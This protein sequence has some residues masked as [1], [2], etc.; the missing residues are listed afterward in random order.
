MKKIA[1]LTSVL[2]LA[3]CSK[4]TANFGGNT[5]AWETPASVR[6]ANANVTQMETWI[7]SAGDVIAWVEGRGVN[8][9]SGSQ[10]SLRASAIREAQSEAFKNATYDKA[11]AEIQNLLDIYNGDKTP[12]KSQLKNA[13]L[14]WGGDES[15]FT[16]MYNKQGKEKDSIYYII[17]HMQ[18]KG[19]D[20]SRI[21]VNIKDDMGYYSLS[22]TQPEFDDIR[23]V[24]F[25]LGALG[26]QLDDGNFH[27]SLND[28]SVITSV[29][30]VN[31]KDDEIGTYYRDM[32]KDKSTKNKD[33]YSNTFG[34]G[35]IAIQSFGKGNLRYA[36][37]GFVYATGADA[38][39][40]G[41]YDMKLRKTKE[42][43][44]EKELL[45]HYK[46]GDDLPALKFKGTAVGLAKKF[47]SG[48]GLLASTRIYTNT[49][50]ATL[51]F[52][53]NGAFTANLPFGSNGSGNFYDVQINSAD[54]SFKNVYIQFRNKEKVDSDF[55]IATEDY[56]NSVKSFDALGFGDGVITEIVSTAT[57]SDKGHVAEGEDYHTVEIVAGFKEQ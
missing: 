32:D 36:D 26:T 47:D 2:A 18:S 28:D 8:L 31:D 12:T 13:W 17:D 24:Q 46:N 57:F 4:G 49:N 50:K 56:N 6:S 43:Y 53:K 9:G 23:N 15:S 10:G 44:T 7:S 34:G 55:R 40:S 16:E 41:G 1:V 52:D 29:T 19:L 48:D 39:F 30:V 22:D 45:A 37:F 35:N 25:N 20:T 3:A 51:D 38:L 14:L 5:V 27:F 21:P 42:L 33:V 54:T 11:I